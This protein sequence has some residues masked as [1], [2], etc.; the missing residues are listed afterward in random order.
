MTPETL[1][2]GA[3]KMGWP[4]SV[5]YCKGKR[6]ELV[7]IVTS[8]LQQ[9][10]RTK[11]MEAKG[12]EQKEAWIGLRRSSLTGNWYWV[13]GETVGNTNWAK[14]EPGTPQDGQCAIMSL[15]STKDFGWSDED[16][17][18]AAHPICYGSPDIFSLTKR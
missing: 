17:C 15:N 18:K 2:I 6:L 13:N 16:C 4:E 1:E 10:I 5:Q 7:S 14:G 8:E 12:E 11:L 9:H 3:E